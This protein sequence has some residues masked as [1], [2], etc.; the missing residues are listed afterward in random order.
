MLEIVLLPGLVAAGVGSLIFI[1]LGSW[2]G[3]ARFRWPFP[4]SPSSASPM[5]PNSAGRW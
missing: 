4:T 5:P 2:S 3:S 1:G